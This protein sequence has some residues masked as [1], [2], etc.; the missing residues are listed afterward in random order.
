MKVCAVNK[1][2]GFIMCGVSMLVFSGMSLAMD[3]DAASDMQDLV[4]GG[5]SSEVIAEREQS[6]Q[7]I[8][9]LACGELIAYHDKTARELFC[10]RLMHRD[11][12]RVKR[13]G[14]RDR[15]EHVAPWL[16]V[17]RR[18]MAERR[19]PEVLH[20]QQVPTRLSPVTEELTE[21]GSQVNIYGVTP[22][23][24]DRTFL[25]ELC[26][27]RRIDQNLLLISIFARVASGD[28]SGLDQSFTARA[29]A[30]EGNGLALVS[31]DQNKEDDVLRNSAGAVSGAAAAHDGDLAQTLLLSQER[32][33]Q[34]SVSFLA[35]VLSAPIAV[36]CWLLG[37]KK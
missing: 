37:K 1:K 23:P 34:P 31:G 32:V 20:R 13:A 7:I 35:R 4:S 8:V 16:I 12:V 24:I 26:R 18:M 36:F 25:T 2:T 22:E 14:D 11:F 19:E 28:L 29:G 27:S 33:E 21:Y 17:V 15:H 3:G 30:T 9:R 5:A 6:G 10:P